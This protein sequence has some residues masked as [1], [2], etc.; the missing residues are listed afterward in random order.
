[1]LLLLVDTSY[2]HQKGGNSVAESIHMIHKPERE[3]SG[4][5]GGGRSGG[6]GREGERARARASTLGQSGMYP[7]FETEFYLK[8]KIMKVKVVIRIGV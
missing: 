4:E 5:E 3:G 7:V 6:G 2:S 8:K 1:M